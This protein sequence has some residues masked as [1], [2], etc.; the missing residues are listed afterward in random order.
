MII[1]GDFRRLRQQKLINQWIEKGIANPFL[2]YVNFLCH[3]FQLGDKRDREIEQSVKKMA[4]WITFT[5]KVGPGP[6]T[7]S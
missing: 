6:K 4:H 2:K 7:P 1:Q 3:S 5:F